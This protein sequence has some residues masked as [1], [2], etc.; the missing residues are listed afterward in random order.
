MRCEAH[1]QCSAEGKVKEIPVQQR[2][3]QKAALYLTELWATY[4]N[5]IRNQDQVWLIQRL[6]CALSDAW[7]A[8]DLAQQKVETL[9][10]DIQAL[11][12]RGRSGYTDV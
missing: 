4:E 1:C 5:S 3:F 10:E 11:T 2:N 8:R 7:T 9:S 6:Q 12:H